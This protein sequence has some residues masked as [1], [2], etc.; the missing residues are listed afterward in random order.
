MDILLWFA[1]PLLAWFLGF[2]ILDPKSFTR[3]FK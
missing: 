2:M 3:F 1:M